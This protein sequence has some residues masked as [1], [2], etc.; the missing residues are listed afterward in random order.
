VLRLCVALALVAALGLLRLADPFGGDQALFLVAGKELARGA[1][2]Y[3][4]F[5][6]VKQPGIFA[7]YTVAGTVGGFRQEALHAVE[8]V[9]NLA[10]T[11]VVATAL[12]RHVRL[13]GSATAGALVITGATYAVTDGSALTQVEGLVG[14][15]LICCCWATIAA[16]EGERTPRAAVALAVAGGLAAGLAIFFKLLFAGIVVAILVTVMVRRR[17]VAL[18]GAWL[19]GAT[20]PLVA[21]ALSALHDGTLPEVVTTFFVL[22]SRIVATAGVAPVQRLAESARWF[23]VGFGFLVPLAALGCAD[24]RDARAA[25]WRDVALAYLI[26]SLAIVLVQVQSWWPYHF[27][28]LIPPLGVLATFG[29]DAIAVRLRERDARRG[30]AVAAL[31]CVGAA[32]LPDALTVAK[33]AAR[34]ARDRPFASESAAER[35]RLRFSGGYARAAAIAAFLDEPRNARGGVYVGGDPRVYLIAAR[36]QAVPINGWALELY[37]PERWRLLEKQIATIRPRYIFIADDYRALVQER[38]PILAEH[39]ARTYVVA[40]STDAGTWYR[41][42]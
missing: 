24:I 7:F 33:S 16:F 2:L 19:V 14:L 5:W 12:R 8:L 11:L 26:A 13:P 21:F 17:R 18:A 41:A 28:L 4:D 42:P 32:L 38:S 35:Y 39:L 1:I 27:L 23:A 20:V 10:L 40:R 9:W 29:I 25:L 30:I 37:P 36:D 15:P 34:I 3:R 6:D 22:P 31:V